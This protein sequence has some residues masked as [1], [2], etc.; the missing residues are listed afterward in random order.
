MSSRSS[1]KYTSNQ[2][3]NCTQELAGFSTK[4]IGYIGSNE[5]SRKTASL[6]CRDDIRAQVGSCLVVKIL[7]AVLSVSSML[8]FVIVDP[9]KIGS[10]LTL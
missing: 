10:H 2:R 4:S 3:N 5:G 9:D 1:L 6:Q 7:D 8:A